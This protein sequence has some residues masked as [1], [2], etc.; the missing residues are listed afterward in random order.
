MLDAIVDKIGEEGLANILAEFDE[1][2]ETM[3]DEEFE[4]DVE[5]SKP[6]YS[7]NCA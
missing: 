7:T 3:E 1:L 6:K 4:E 2:V 5:E